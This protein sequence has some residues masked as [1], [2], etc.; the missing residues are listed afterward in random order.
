[1]PGSATL[2]HR[3]RL[4]TAL[5]AAVAV[6]VAGA[7]LAP[8]SASAAAATHT[9]RGSI[10]VPKGAS[11]ADYLEGVSLEWRNSS[12]KAGAANAYGQATLDART[13]AFT[14]S[15]VDAGTYNVRLAGATTVNGIT[16]EWD[17]TPGPVKPT[18]VGGS[19]GGGKGW[20]VDTPWVWVAVAGGDVAADP[21]SAPAFGVITGRLVLAEALPRGGDAELFLEAKGVN[22]PAWDILRTYTPVRPGV[23]DQT[24]RHTVGPGTFDVDAV[25]RA[26]VDNT[27]K[28]WRYVGTRKITVP[29]FGSAAMDVVEERPTVSGT[30][31]VGQTVR[32]SA[33]TWP[34]DSTLTYQ[35]LRNGKAIS[36]AKNSSYAV[37]S[38]DATTKLSVRVSGPSAVWGPG[39][40]DTISR[41]SPTVTVARGTLKT[42]TPTIAG[43]ARVGQK[44]TAKP[45]TWTSGTTFS[46]QWLR[47]GKAIAGARKSA[48]VATSADYRKKLTVRVVGARSGYASVTKSSASKTVAAGV[49]KA[50]TPRITGPAKAGRTLTAVPGAWTPG[51]KLGYQWRADGT[52]IKGATS[53]SYKVSASVRG[54]RITVSVT[55]TKAGYATTRLTS[56]STASVAR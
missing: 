36:G 30:A 41:T 27:Y 20:G 13:G 32:A 23:L 40:V 5:L 47:D 7:A 43:T 9:I 8:A 21:I 44:L 53:S 56:R 45:G 22:A 11:T 14:I 46:Y 17:G 25:A 52:A 18:V 29:A 34:P 10:V 12:W 28:T 50:G 26:Y 54:K 15:G 4:M 49:L 55:G 42:A 16:V 51:T 1:M 39:S 37:T 19:A 48:Y 38:A 6:V 24:W 33:G 2:R 31:K 35:W 3:S